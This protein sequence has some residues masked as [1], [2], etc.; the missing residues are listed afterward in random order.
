M[1]ARC[2]ARAFVPED[3]WVNPEQWG[4]VFQRQLEDR[5]IYEML[6]LIQLATQWSHLVAD[7][8]DPNV[9]RVPRRERYPFSFSHLSRAAAASEAQAVT[10]G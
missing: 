2:H 8:I 3:R 7:A 10:N 1:Q 6:G 9:S 4:L 5:L